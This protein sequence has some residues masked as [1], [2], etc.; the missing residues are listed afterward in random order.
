MKNKPTN[1]EM[2]VRN[3]VRELSIRD[4][5]QEDNNSSNNLKQYSIDGY[6]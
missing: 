3:C 2:K 6:V 4:N 1:N 5:L